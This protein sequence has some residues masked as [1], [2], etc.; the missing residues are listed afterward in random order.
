MKLDLDRYNER[1]KEAGK[2]LLHNIQ[3]EAND[4]GIEHREDS[5]SRGSSVAA[6]KDSYGAHDGAV[7]RISIK[8]RRSLIYP[9]K[10]AG[11]GRGGT[12]GSKWV[13]KFGVT[14]STNKNSLGKMGTGGRV[15]KPFINQVI[16]SEKG[17]E[18]IATIAAEELGDAIVNNMLVK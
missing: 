11:K 7:D 14:K 18:K 13:D 6:M 12:K 2:E 10:G 4:M 9:H 1:L 3:E 16:E 8:F 15:A 17:V 5:P